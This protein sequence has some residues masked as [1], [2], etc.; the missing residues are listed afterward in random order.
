[1]P[2]NLANFKNDQNPPGIR[3]EVPDTLRGVFQTLD[4][5][6]VTLKKKM[7]PSLRRNIK[8][9]DPTKTL[10]LDVC[11]PDDSQWTR[12]SHDLAAEEMI[13][14]RRQESESVRGPLNSITEAQDKPRQEGTADVIMIEDSPVLT[15]SNTLR[16][17]NKNTADPPRR[18]GAK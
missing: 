14:I 10:I 12:I 15:Q 11:F 1:M 18:W 4:L 17:I 7:G 3:L 2:G 9:H 5:Y 16:S 8:F 13:K 6:A